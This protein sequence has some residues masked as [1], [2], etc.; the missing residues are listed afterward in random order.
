MK[1]ENFLIIFYGV[2]FLIDIKFELNCG[3]RYGL[4]GLNGCG[5]FFM[6]F[7]KYI[8]IG[9]FSFIKFKVFFLNRII[10]FKEILIDLNNFFCCGEIKY[11]E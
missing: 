1:I 11:K 5:R 3:W 7:W 2:E 6:F 10:Y 4:L 8:Y 9:F